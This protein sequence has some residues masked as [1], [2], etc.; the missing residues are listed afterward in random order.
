MLRNILSLALLLVS[1]VLSFR[2]GWSSLNIRSNPDASKMLTALGLSERYVP[3][4]GAA[5]IGIGFLLMFPKT[6]FAGNLLNAFSILVIMALALHSGN[7]RIALM[8]IPFLILPLALIGLRY[9]FST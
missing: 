1:V 8:E 9:P 5:L 4:M 6:F 3:V 7:F 2:H